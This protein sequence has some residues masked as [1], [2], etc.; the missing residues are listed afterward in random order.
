M[1]T[2]F[3]GGVPIQSTRPCAQTTAPPRW[4]G[5][6]R[7]GLTLATL[8]VAVGAAA[9]AQDVVR[10]NVPTQIM[11][12]EQRDL[13]G[14][15][16]VDVQRQQATELVQQSDRH[17]GGTL[18][19]SGAVIA[20]RLVEHGD[21]VDFGVDHDADGTVEPGETRRVAVQTGG[22]P[23]QGAQPRLQLRLPPLERIAGRNV[24]LQVRRHE[25][26]RWI[27][28]C[29]SEVACRQGSASVNGQEHVLLLIDRDDDARFGSPGD[30]FTWLPRD[31]FAAASGFGA[32]RGYSF[33]AAEPCI[34]TAT[35]VARWLACAGDGTAVIELAPS[36][37]PL[38]DLLR[39]R[40]A[41]ASACVAREFAAGFAA[42]ER[43]QGLRARVAAEQGIPWT[44]HL[45]AAEALA[46]AR[47]EQ[48]PLFLLFE[49]DA[50][51]RCA[52]MDTFIWHRDDVAAAAASFC[53]A[54]VS[55]DLDLSASHRDFDVR[56]GP[57]YVFCS[58]AGEPLRYIDKKSGRVVRM[59]KG[60]KT[61]AE[62]VALLT[63][64]ARRLA[65]GAF[66]PEPSKR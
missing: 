52:Q 58:A 34:A 43:E 37:V 30:V 54:R 48:K 55:I 60:L 19:L 24:A 11:P 63:E 9:A 4:R 39:D 20:I 28:E 22:Q 7:G 35:T 17:W 36:S 49:N 29:A 10:V 32:W 64:S 27:V 26:G 13:P 3:H 31:R 53:C 33:F 2:S 47:A 61:P 18:S 59:S 38:A 21:E 40:R 41:R 45:A 46:R 62:M 1:H 14:T 6:G 15:P 50:D 12:R 25:D 5:A 51:E 56:L 65:A 44:W 42:L 8:L 57:A 66:D 23:V 16:A